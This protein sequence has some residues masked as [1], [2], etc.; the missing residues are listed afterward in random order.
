MTPT[1]ACA[2][3]QALIDDLRY[4]MGTRP[5]TGWPTM[6][7]AALEHH[8]PEIAETLLDEAHRG[9]QTAGQ[10]ALRG[11]V[12]SDAQEIRSAILEIRRIETTELPAV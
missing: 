12:A 9:L 11:L 2:S 8:R 4:I 6:A 10:R 5:H 7:S 1:E 3:V